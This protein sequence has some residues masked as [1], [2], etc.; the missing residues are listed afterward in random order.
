MTAPLPEAEVT[1][2]LDVLAFYADQLDDRRHHPRI[3]LEALP[4]WREEAAA[5]EAGLGRDALTLAD[6]RAGRYYRPSPWP[7]P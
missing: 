3:A 6:V 5:G 4:R 1:A 7:W 2:L